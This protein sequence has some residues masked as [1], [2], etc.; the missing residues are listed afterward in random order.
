MA[1]VTLFH[2]KARAWLRPVLIVILGFII[3]TIFQVQR[4]AAVRAADG[5]GYQGI[6]YSASG[7][8]NPTGEKPQ[9]KLW[10][11]AN[12]WW[13]NLYN[14]DAGEYRIHWLDWT[15]QS[16]MDTGVATDDRE[17]SKADTLWDGTYLYVASGTDDGPGRLYRYTYANNDYTPSPGFPV[18]VT[19]HGMEALVLAKDSQGQLWITYTRSSSVYIA[20]S[21][22][23]DSTWVSPYVLPISGASGL[24]NDDISAIIA[25]QERIGVMWSNQEEL[26][27]YFAVHEDG[28]PDDSWQSIG[29]YDPSADDHINLK[30]LQA[31]SA[32]NV[33]AVVKTSF[34]SLGEPGIVLLACTSGDCSA[35]GNWQAH[36]V[37]ERVSGKQKTRPILLIDTENRDL[38]VFAADTG[39]GA[40]YYKKSSIDAISFADGTGTIFID[41][42]Q[43]INDPSSTKQNLTSNTHLVVI[44][45]DN[46]YYYHNCLTLTEATECP[47]PAATP[48]PTATASSTPT[49]TA[50]VTPTPT[51]TPSP[52][53]Q[54]SEAVDLT[55]Y[56]P[57]IQR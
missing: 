23:D 47:D 26:K 51:A 31:D 39:G 27:M 50:T 42:D 20:H 24:K 55:L 32:G 1:A 7:V 17:A 34:S 33:F 54:G 45:S 53:P 15:T 40:I 30:S 36:V 56:L 3:I 25:F 12:T 46:N 22:G 2:D 48:T 18:T 29:A 16:W 43:D 44:A 28:A 8:E 35:A 10:Y 9:S 6:E 13:G 52:T 19:D 49:P 41:F 38:Y 11:T 57:L 4:M 5:V 21:S 14:K 37:Y